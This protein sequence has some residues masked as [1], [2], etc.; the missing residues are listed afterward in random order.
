MG[1]QG[2]LS[3]TRLRV[4]AKILGDMVDRAGHAHEG[5]APRGR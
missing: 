5:S 2:A 1:L 4:A 3:V